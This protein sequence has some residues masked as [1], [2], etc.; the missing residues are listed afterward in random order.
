MSAV[1]WT[2]E[3]RAEVKNRTA[4]P[5]LWVGMVSILMFFGGLTSALVVQAGNR[6]WLQFPIPDAF[7]VSTV[8]MVLSSVTMILAVRAAKK[9]NSGMVLTGVLLT[10]L[11]G[12]GFTVS[13]FIGYGDLV[14]M[15]IHFAD[16]SNVAGSFF[17]AI[18]GAHLAHLFG[19]LIAL[20]VTAV[21]AGQG[22]YNATNLLGL[23][24]CSIYWHFLD[25]LWIYLLLFLMYYR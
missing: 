16:A 22:R 9:N 6:Q 1:A 13:Q 17:Y 4:K 7:M 3:E 18:T 24:L 2:K 12:V 15:R 21:S 10:L 5:L 8:L 25:G 19:G 11:L 14:D 20:I 23:Q